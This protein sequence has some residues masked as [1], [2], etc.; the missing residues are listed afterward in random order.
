MDKEKILETVAEQKEGVLSLACSASISLLILSEELEPEYY[1]DLDFIDACRQLV[2]RHERCHM[3][4]LI[5]NAENLRRQEHRLLGLIQRLP[6]RMEIKVCHEED[7]DYPQA[8]ML[9][10]STGLFLK[11]LPGRNKAVIYTDAP[12]VNDEYRKVFQGLWDRAES[13][14]NLQSVN[15]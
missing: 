15:L 1:D 3:K 6:S 8:F 2:I 12:R 11:R 13:D 9:A 10:D 5:K 7:R 14:R 4:I